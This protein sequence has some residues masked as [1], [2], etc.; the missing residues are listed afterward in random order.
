MI[1]SAHRIQKT[2]KTVPVLLRK[3][4]VLFL[5]LHLVNFIFNQTMIYFQELRMSSR[6]DSY[7]PYMLAIA[8][9][10]FFVQAGIKVIWTFIVCH[11]FSKSNSSLIDFIRAYLEKGIIESLRA[12]LKSVRWGF[13]FIIPGLVKAIRYQFVTF[14]ICTDENYEKGEIDVLNASEKLTQ[15]HLLSLFILFVIFGLISF[16]TSS[17]QL[18]IK[19]PFL[20]GFTELFNV[21]LFTFEITYIYYIF[22]DLKA[23]GQE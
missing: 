23:K 15:K 1:L 20:V 21:I 11:N 18:F 17:S 7:I 19:K 14:I 4:A 8:F 5:C 2:L 3:Y 10:G 16:S 6:E 13:L 12:F 22:N 9:V